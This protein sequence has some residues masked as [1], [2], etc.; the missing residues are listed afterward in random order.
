MKLTVNANSGSF[1]QCFYKD[2]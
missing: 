1:V 2:G